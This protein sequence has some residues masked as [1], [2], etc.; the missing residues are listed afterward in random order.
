M[1]KVPVG[2]KSILEFLKGHKQANKHQI[3]SYVGKT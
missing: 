2:L 3:D 1:H